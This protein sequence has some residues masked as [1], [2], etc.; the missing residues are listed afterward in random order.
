MKTL[1]KA[2]ALLLS[3]MMVFSVCSVAINAQADY[4]AGLI[5]IWLSS[6]GG[7]RI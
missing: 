6:S 4:G 5:K 2:L 3:I 1:K 7:N